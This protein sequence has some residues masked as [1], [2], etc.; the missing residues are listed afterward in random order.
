MPISDEQRRDEQFRV[1]GLASR[2]RRDGR[3]VEQRGAQ[4]RDRQPDGGD[5]D[6]IRLGWR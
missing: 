5:F 1:A 3:A 2:P 6:V 4:H